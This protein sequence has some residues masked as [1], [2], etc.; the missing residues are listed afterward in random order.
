MGSNEREGIGPKRNKKGPAL[1][2]EESSELG[3]TLAASFGVAGEVTGTAV[4]VTQ[5][6]LGSLLC[7]DGPLHEQQV[8]GR[9][10]V[11]SFSTL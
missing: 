6:S 2:V 8:L 5:R 10:V 11:P 9:D 3:T 1:A 7:G 4:A